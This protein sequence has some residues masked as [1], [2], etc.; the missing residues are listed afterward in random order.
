MWR[1]PR[2]VR[3]VAG[4]SNGTSSRPRPCSTG[5][6]RCGR[7]SD[8]SLIATLRHDH[9]R[10][11]VVR[12][13]NA[14]DADSVSHRPDMGR[15]IPASSCG[16]PASV[17]CGRHRR[18]RSS[19]HRHGIGA[20]S[21]DART[22]SRCCRVQGPDVRVCRAPGTTRGKGYYRDSSC[23]IGRDGPLSDPERSSV[24]SL[25]SGD[26]RT[27][28]TG[29]LA[30]LTTLVVT[31]PSSTPTKPPR[32]LEPTTIMSASAASSNRTSAG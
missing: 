1:L 10:A 4:G 3:P 25:V 6:R 9:Q 14:P 19:A 21:V 11:V 30:W 32:P 12:R 8:A 2:S 18:P 28:T 5:S 22:G 26:Q 16:R 20:A 27:T 31:E 15:S 29:H 7:H 13:R 17:R 24:R 23:R